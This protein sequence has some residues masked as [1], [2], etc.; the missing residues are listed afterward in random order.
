MFSD[1]VKR[2]GAEGPERV[3]SANAD[4]LEWDSLQQDD[5]AIAGDK[6]RAG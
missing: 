6:H 5:I 3:G 2:Q 1:K 4:S